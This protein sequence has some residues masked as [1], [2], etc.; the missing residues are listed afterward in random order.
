[1]SGD[2]DAGRK[3]LAEVGHDLL[4]ESLDLGHDLVWGAGVGE[5]EVGDANVGE[6]LDG[7]GDVVGGAEGVV[8]VDGWREGHGALISVLKGF[9]GDVL[10]LGA[11][12]VDAKVELDGLGDGGRVPAD[13]SAVLLDSAPQVLI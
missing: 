4:S 6:G 9:F 13:G 5:G 2:G 12:V 11:S 7:A 8:G 10:G 1:M 3:G